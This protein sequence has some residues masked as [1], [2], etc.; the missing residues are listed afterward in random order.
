MNKILAYDYGEDGKTAR[1]ADFIANALSQGLA[2]G[3]YPDGLCLDK[4]GGVWS[5]R[6]VLL[7]LFHIKSPSEY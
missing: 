2:E 7:R 3:S 1:K 6:Y 5:A 4:D